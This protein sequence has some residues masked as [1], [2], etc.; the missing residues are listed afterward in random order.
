MWEREEYDDDE[1]YEDENYRSHIASMLVKSTSAWMAL[2]YCAANALHAEG[3][4]GTA[5]CVRVWV[6][7]WVC[8]CECLVLSICCAGMRDGDARDLE[9]RFCCL[10]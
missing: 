2:L 1:E 7:V 4:C 9:E 5:L 3:V 8:L 10:L 6:C